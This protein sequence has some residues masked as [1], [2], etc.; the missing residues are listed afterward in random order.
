MNA[1][2]ELLG[3]I[4]DYAGLFPPAAL[5]MP[6]AVRNYAA[7]R[8]DP[9]AWM[10][11]RFVLPVARFTEF[12]DAHASLAGHDAEPWRV[13]ALLGPDA[14]LDIARVDAFNAMQAGRAVVDSL[15]GKFTTPGEIE[16][17]AE[18][19]KGRMQLYAEIPLDRD[20][21]PLIAAVKRAGVRAKMRTGGV[22]ADSVPPPSLVV[23]FMR[24]C[25]DANVTFKATAGLHHPLRAEYPLTYDAGAASGVM[26]GYLNV[27]L[28]AAVMANGA[29]DADAIRVLEERDPSAFSFDGEIRWREHAI[30]ASH[31]K[32][33]RDR[34]AVSFGSCSFREPV[35]E[36]QSLTTV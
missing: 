16:T 18:M 5:D 13:S 6:S 29:S 15:E 23:R 36:L 21:E 8:G 22:V 11:G 19:V 33:V 17:A 20:P 1:L 26:F 7:Y 24:A 10:L 14:R 3:G 32:D 27:F 2:R 25:L 34:I 12:A 28:A 9:G 31:A 4:V 30:S 35:D